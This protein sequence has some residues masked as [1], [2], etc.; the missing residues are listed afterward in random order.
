MNYYFRS[1]AIVA[2]IIIVCFSGC[3]LKNGEKEFEGTEAFSERDEMQKAMQQEFMMTVDPALGYVPKE[4]LTAALAYE[5]KLARMSRGNAI[6][7]QE[8]GPANIS[9]R[10]RAVI[11]DSRDATNNTVF[12]GSVSGGIWKTTNFKATNP[13]WTPVNESMGSIAVCALAQDPSSPNTIYAGTGE[14]WF[15]SDAV[16]GNGIW[17]STDGGTTWNK[18]ATTDST[19]GNTHDFDFV[20]DIVVNNQGIVFASCRSVFCNRGGILRSANGGATWTRVIGRFVNGATEPCDSA[21]NFFGTDLELASNGDMYACTGLSIEFAQNGRIFRSGVANGSNIGT[22]NTWT[23]ITPAGIWQRIEI[24][25]APSNPA[26][27]YALLEGPSDGIGAIKKS[28]NFGAT[29]INLPNPSWCNQGSTSNDFT[30]GQ[31]FYNLIVQVD[32]DDENTVIIGGIDLFKSTNGGASWSQITQW[33][34]GCSGLPSIHADQHNVLFFP[35]STN[36]LIATND[37]GIYYSSTGGSTWVT[38]TATNVN[39]SISIS[40]SPKNFGYNVTQ[41]YACDIHPTQTNYFLAGAQD[42]GTQRFNSAGLNTTVEASIGGDGGFCHIDQTDGSIQ[43]LSN[44]YNNYFYSRNGGNSFSRMD[45]NSSGFFINPSDYDDSKKVL[46]SAYL[47]GQ[48]GIISNLTTASPSFASRSIPELGIRKVSAVKVDPTVSGGGTIWIA[49]W[50]SSRVPTS[51]NVIKLTN[52]NTSPVAAVSTTLT[53]APGGSY[54]SSI[55]VDP[56]NANHILITLSNYG[57]VSVYESTNGGTSFANIEGNLPDIPVRWGMFL[58]ATTSVDGVTGGGILVAT[59][60]GVWFAQ[61]TNGSITAWTPLNTGLPNVRTDMLRLRTSDNLLAAAT[62]GRGLFTTNLA[63]IGGGPVVPPPAA[64]FINYIS[65]TRQE[66]FIKVGNLNITTMQVRLFAADGKLVY[67][68]KTQYASQTIPISQLATGTY[69]VK[70]D[71]SENE[72]FTKK[73]VK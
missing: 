12:A 21:Y 39:G 66:L 40:Y 57:I 63:S 62:H 29:W 69:I 9:G 49:G 42:N 22:S 58:P 50:D 10:T 25:I 55:D 3:I 5:R 52:S 28:T 23:D 41:F 17:K 26:V 53:A 70:I 38:T 30:N 13:T 73:F 60:V 46:Y 72:H 33:S 15:N 20:Q 59:E 6:T 19:A 48:L 44:V 32:P 37:G 43:I 7:W 61:T 24:A 11:I 8:R 14:G 36:E 18:L 31:A 71:G 16:R 68:S 51:P 64:S 1:L 4:R 2:V 65:A 67:S 34:R 47:P 56:G 54:I 45:F 35:S 27:V